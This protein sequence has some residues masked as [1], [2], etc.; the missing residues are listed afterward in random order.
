MTARTELWKQGKVTI[1][2]C[3]NG[4]ERI[5]LPHGTVH[6]SKQERAGR[7]IV[8]VLASGGIIYSGSRADD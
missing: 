7:Q 5:D 2:D 6:V 1:T 4:T 8:H 3:G